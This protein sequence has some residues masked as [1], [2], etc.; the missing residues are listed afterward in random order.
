LGHQEHEAT[1]LAPATEVCPS[2][3]HISH[4]PVNKLKYDPGSQE[5]HDAA[6]GVEF[7]PVAQGVHVETEV[8]PIAAEKVPA[9]HGMHT[10]PAVE[11]VPGAQEAHLLT[12]VD[13]GGEDFPAS[14]GLHV[15]AE[16]APTA[17]E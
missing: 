4:K 15:V 2:Y 3:G 6:P 17:A 11:Y 5:L 16:V 7:V 13:A 9:L 14:Q 12:E 8:A 10:D 1:P